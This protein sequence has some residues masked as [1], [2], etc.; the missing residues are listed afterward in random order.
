MHSVSLP[1]TLPFPTSAP[2]T[3][4]LAAIS[5][6]SRFSP[7]AAISYD[8]ASVPV[9][10][11]EPS[12]DSAV[13]A[14]WD[15][16][17]LFASQRSETRDPILL[18][19]SEG[20][21]PADLPRGIYYL[22][23]PGLLSD[24]HG[25]S[26]NP[27]DGHGYLRAFDFSGGDSVW[28]SARYVETE[29]QREEMDGETRRWRFTHRGTFSVLRGG[30]RV[31][32]LKV[33][34][35]V[36]NTC[37]VRWGGRLLCMWEGGDPYEVDPKTLGTIGTVNL[38]RDLDLEA[39]GRH[40]RT[41]EWRWLWDL[42]IDVA[43]HFLKPILRGVFKMPPKRL[44]SHYKIDGKRKRLIVLACN[45]EDM[46]LP[47]SNFTFYEF[48]GD[49]ELKQR[50]E[51]SVED[52]LLIHDWSFTDSYYVLMGNRIKLDVAGSL[53]AASG[54]AP[55]VSALAPDPRQPSTP[56]YLLPRFSDDLQRD[57]SV[58]IEAPGQLWSSHFSNSFEEQGTHGGLVVQLQAAVCS[59]QW[60]NFP[61]MFGYDWRSSRLDPAY[62]NA[63]QDKEA[64]LSHLVR[65]PS[66]HWKRSA[67]FPA[68][69]PAFAGNKNSYVYAATSSR[70]CRFLPHFPFDT[71][72]KLNCLDGSVSS[73]CSGSRRFIGEPTFVPSIGGKEEDDGY[74]LVAEY[75]VS[76]QRCHLVILDAKRMGEANAVKA[77]LEVPRQLTFPFGFHGFW[78]N[79]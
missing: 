43:A 56:I 26:V 27:L 23:G 71:V 16:Q 42:G 45:T 9:L 20:S 33:M 25:S 11:P 50:K 31:G 4:D 22:V 63:T 3:K 13:A 55:M 49:F 7:P 52:H 51:F 38:I 35:N 8:A 6:F 65:E 30:K 44:L 2:A 1:L 62:M 19:V 10:R 79:T 54:M 74:I 78:T 15:Y 17:F 73:W 21:I 39:G 53:V 12:G 5:R 34:K 24:D 66:E 72:V 18:R 59:Y 64:L 37:V 47:R 67:D 61:K 36:A 40:R 57:W 76:K 46:L 32:N 14:Y 48:D 68:I 77:K 60:I 75:E 28:Y 69:N 70:S 58:P 41:G 29:A